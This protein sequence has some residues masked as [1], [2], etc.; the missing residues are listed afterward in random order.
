[1]LGGGWARSEL[2]LFTVQAL[3]RVERGGTHPRGPRSAPYM[4][5]QL[6]FLVPCVR[7]L[8]LKCSTRA[9]R[10]SSRALHFYRFAHKNAI[11]KSTR[12]ISPW[13]NV[14]STVLTPFQNHNCVCILV[15]RRVG[16]N[17]VSEGE[18][19]LPIEVANAVYMATKLT[20]GSCCKHRTLCSLRVPLKQ[21]LF[22]MSWAEKYVDFFQ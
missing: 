7:A 2:G 5:T 21:T 8:I 19:V 16:S 12:L 3:M 1:M 15:Y 10:C 17:A 11:T 14:P 6:F 20:L 4:P 13:S 18:I 9:A 22:M